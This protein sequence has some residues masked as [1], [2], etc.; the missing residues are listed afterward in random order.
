MKDRLQLEELLQR[1]GA[2]LSA[3]NARLQQE[4][5]DRIE[6]EIRLRQEIHLN[7]ILLNNMPCVAILVRPGTREIIAANEMA[8]KAGAVPGKQCFATLG[9]QK[10]PCP[11][12]L[13]SRLWDA[14][15]AQQLE[16]EVSGVMWDVRW[17][18]VS[19]NLYMRY[20]SDITERKKLEKSLIETEERERRRIGQDLHDGLGQLLT[21]ISFKTSGLV[22]KLENSCMEGAEDAAA[23]SILVDKAK[24]EVSRMSKGL[25]PVETDKEGLMAALDEL[26]D[27]TEKIFGIPCGFKCDKPV[28][29]RNKTAVVQLYRIAQEAVTNAV[30]HGKPGNVEILLSEEHGKILMI[31][32]D[33]GT[34]IPEMSRYAGGMGMKIM[35]YRAGII[36]GSFDVRRDIGGGT[37]ATCIL[38]DK[39]G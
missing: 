8:L 10:D 5:I 1:K 25:L 26:A 20:A 13:A 16:V 28:T 33:D 24:K 21:G 11:W 29:V 32:K 22:R 37:V 38:P 39:P 15:E 36:N 3:A 7:R 19:D 30:K 2:E 31:I 18:P 14:G 17:F 6:N 34:G 23:I 27:H 12:C 4:I 9:Q 35:K